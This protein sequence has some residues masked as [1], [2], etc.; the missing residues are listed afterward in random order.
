MVCDEDPLE[1]RVR[2]LERLVN[3]L[4]SSLKMLIAQV[5]ELEGEIERLKDC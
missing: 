5:E 1:L 4:Q 3:G 2:E